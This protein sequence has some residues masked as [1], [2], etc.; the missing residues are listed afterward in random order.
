MTWQVEI[1]ENAPHQGKNSRHYV[2]ID[3]IYEARVFRK[4]SQWAMI[5]KDAATREVVERWHRFRNKMQACA[6]AEIELD[7]LLGR[8]DEDYVD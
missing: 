1:Y 7:R 2:L 8:V 4:N 6:Q 3:D 5:I